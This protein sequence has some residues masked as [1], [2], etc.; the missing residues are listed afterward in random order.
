[1]TTAKIA[2]R[3]SLVALTV[4]Q[5]ILAF[6]LPKV[7]VSIGSPEF[8]KTWFICS[9]VVCLV[10]TLRPVRGVTIPLAGAVSVVAFLSR[11][12][13]DVYSHDQLPH[14]IQGTTEWSLMAV[15][16]WAVCIAIARNLPPR[17]G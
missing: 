16:T 8:W 13:G 6:Q 9:A 2:I 4:G 3:I 11:A 1:M 10:A 5:F 14:W 12:F 7:P 17:A 15:L